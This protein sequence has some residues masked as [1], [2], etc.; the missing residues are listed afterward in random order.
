MAER[1]TLEQLSQNSD[2]NVRAF[3][4]ELLA[5]YEARYEGAGSPADAAEAIWESQV[6][7]YLARYG[8]GGCPEG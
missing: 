7:S 1:R 4:K 3:A 2:P 5:A 6:D 8:D